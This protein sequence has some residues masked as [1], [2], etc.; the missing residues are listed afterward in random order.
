MVHRHFGPPVFFSVLSKAQTFKTGSFERSSA[1]VMRRD[2]FGT[3][4]SCAID[5]VAE[6]AALNERIALNAR[7]RMRTFPLE[8]PKK[9]VSAPVAMEI[10][11]LC[12]QKRVSKVS[13]DSALLFLHRKDSCHLRL[14]APV[15]RSWRRIGRLS[16]M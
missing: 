14:Q 13:A 2:V 1:M 12:D 10:R 5:A 11:S 16:K 6:S 3:C 15:V 9:M 7:E 8:S 4:F